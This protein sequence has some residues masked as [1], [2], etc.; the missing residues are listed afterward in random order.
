MISAHAYSKLGSYAART[1][2]YEIYERPWRDLPDGQSYAGVLMEMTLNNGQHFKDPHQIFL[3]SWKGGLEVT[4]IKREDYENRVLALLSKKHQKKLFTGANDHYVDK[5]AHFFE[6]VPI[7][8]H[9]T[10]IML[11]QEQFTFKE[12]I[13]KYLNS[14]YQHLYDAYYNNYDNPNDV[15]IC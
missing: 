13:D 1:D 3:I 4:R 7:D 9:M 10:K 8:T 5:A 11:M 12:G 14:Y 15:W 6:D 2:R